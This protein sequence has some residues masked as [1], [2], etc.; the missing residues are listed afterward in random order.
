MSSTESSTHEGFTAEERAAMKD[1]AQELKT[2]ASR[3]SRAGKAAEKAAEAEREVP[4][5]WISRRTPIPTR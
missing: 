2:A 1:H 5:R 4:C 3:S